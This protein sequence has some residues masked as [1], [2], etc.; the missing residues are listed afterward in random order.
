MNDGAAAGRA[1]TRRGWIRTLFAFERT[2]FAPWELGIM[3]ALFA[4]VVLRYTSFMWPIEWPH[5]GNGWMFR[6]LP[7]SPFG[8]QPEP[9]GLAR[10]FD[11]TFLHEPSVFAVIRGVFLAGILMYAAGL[12]VPVALIA[13]LFANVTIATLNV[14]QGAVGHS[15]QVIGIPLLLQTIAI[16]IVLAPRWGGLRNLVALSAPAERLLVDWTRQ[17]VVATYLVTGCTKLIVSQGRWAGRGAEFV[18]QIEKAQTEALHDTGV[19]VSDLAQ[20]VTGFLAEHPFCASVMLTVA[21]AVELTA[22][23]ALLNRRM[24]GLIGLLLLGFHIANGFLM[25][26]PFL[27]NRW[28]LMI[29][30]INVPFWMWAGARRLTKRG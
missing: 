18:M 12:V 6:F 5:P 14:S 10:F 23:L 22:P 15:G 24:S 16:L 19:A 8:S 28:M 21:L 7:A 17:G 2:D 26:L 3:R 25:R 27:E 30:F 4:F 13:M 20:R 11:L 29:F 9:V 1:G